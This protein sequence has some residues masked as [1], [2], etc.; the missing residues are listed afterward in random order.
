MNLIRKL[1]RTWSERRLKARAD[2]RVRP[3]VANF[4]RARSVALVYREKG[5]GFFIL[6]K[7]YVK[8]LKAEQGIPEV[9]AMAYIEDDRQVPHYHLHRLRYDFFTTKETDLFSEPNCEQAAKFTDRDFD[10]LIDLE[11]EPSLSLQYLVQRCKARFKVG[12]YSE[13]RAY[14]YDM[15]IKAGEHAT[16]DE[17]AKQ[18]NHYLNII[19]NNEARA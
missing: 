19:D 4:G 7:Q 15:M 12:Y 16:F 11:K 18:V 17:Y 3:K 9:L 10:I 13:E 5:E 2:V 8:Y 6:V 1:L 14:L